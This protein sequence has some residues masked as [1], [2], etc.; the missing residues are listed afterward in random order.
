[1]TKKNA[2]I[3][4]FLLLIFFSIFSFGS[5][6]K[7]QNNAD[8]QTYSFSIYL[9][10]YFLKPEALPNSYALN[11]EYLAAKQQVLA[12]RIG[13][14]PDVSNSFKFPITLAALIGIN[15]TIQ[16]EVGAG[17]VLSLNPKEILFNPDIRSLIIPVMA[18]FELLDR[19]LIRTGINLFAKQNIATLSPGISL[20]VRF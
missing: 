4:G 14:F 16:M 17:I 18:R 7:A 13:L 1:M 2:F 9:E 19:I 11:V 10:T 3:Q 12:I 6:L 15:S 8:S 5:Q 20:G